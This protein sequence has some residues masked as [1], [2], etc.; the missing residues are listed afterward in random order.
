M[1]GIWHRLHGFGV[2]MPILPTL[3]L[4]QSSSAKGPHPRTTML[5]SA[6]SKCPRHRTHRQRR[7]GVRARGQNKK[8]ERERWQRSAEDIRREK[9]DFGGPRERVDDE[10]KYI[11]IRN[12]SSAMV[13]LDAQP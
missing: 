1:P 12:R 6:A 10:N 11:R 2:R 5:C 8:Q 4:V 9:R 13:F 7:A 3:I